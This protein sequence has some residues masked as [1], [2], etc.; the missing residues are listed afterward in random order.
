[1]DDAMQLIDFGWPCSA[2]LNLA[3]E[4]SLFARLERTGAL[5]LFY[6]DTAAVVIGRN[7]MPWAEVRPDA[8]VSGGVPLVRR[9]SG[10]GTVYHDPGN[11]NYSLMLPAAAPGRPA[12]AAILEP[13]VRALRALGLPARL[14][15]RNA[16]FVGRHKVSG[17]A[18]FMTAGRILTH[19]T[20]LVDADLQRLTDCL[21]PDPALQINSRGRPSIASPV[22]NLSDLEPA[23]TMAE[24]RRALVSACADAYGPIAERPLALAVEEAARLLTREKYQTWE[25]NIGRSPPGRITWEGNF[26]GVAC[27]CRL[28][29]RR[30]MIIRVQVD[31]SG[32]RQKQLQRWAQ[33]WLQGRR[34][35]DITVAAH[36]RLHQANTSD[37]ARA[38]FMHWLRA[39]LPKPLPISS[40]N[41]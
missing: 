20:L 16:V 24:L 40:E 8:L 9:M 23:V 35:G 21:G 4:E 31:A 17:T 41:I 30:G 27:R 22:A 26:K 5:L 1:M 6:V 32:H 29:V 38:A 18:Q 10:G 14:S 39:G 12:A 19:G 15:A 25:W 11:L 3:R 28:H 33:S 13:V 2:A 36:E 37:G 7:Q 34:L